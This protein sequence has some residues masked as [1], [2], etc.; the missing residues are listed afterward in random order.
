MNSHQPML[1]IAVTC[2]RCCSVRQYI[3]L[4]CSSALRSDGVRVASDFLHFTL[5]PA[6]C[7]SILQRVQCVAVCCNILQRVAACYSVLQ[8]V[9]V[10]REW[11]HAIHAILLRNFCRK[12]K[13]AVL[14]YILLLSP[15]SFLSVYLSTYP[16]VSDSIYPCI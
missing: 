11:V 4:C 1:C 12:R 7:C 13:K 2:L 15:P 5:A 16:S 3:A 8:C 9:A 10:F 14:Y 6:L